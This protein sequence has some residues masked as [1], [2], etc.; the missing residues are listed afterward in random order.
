MAACDAVTVCEL[1][2]CSKNKKERRDRQSN[3]SWTVKERLASVEQHFRDD[4]GE[5]TECCFL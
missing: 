3:C 2:G 4:D 5:V 1:A